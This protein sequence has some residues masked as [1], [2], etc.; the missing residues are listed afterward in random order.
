MS[1]KISGRVLSRHVDIFH[2]LCILHAALHLGGS[3][4]KLDVP[5][6]Q[7]E[8]NNRNVCWVISGDFFTGIISN[9]KYYLPGGFILPIGN[10]DVGMLCILGLCPHLWVWE[11]RRAYWT[12]NI[13]AITWIRSLRNVVSPELRP[14]GKRGKDSA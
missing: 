4:E 7:R 10:R 1:E 2:S 6:L 3:G 9:V 12:F 8:R 11:L 5:R 14:G 13:Y